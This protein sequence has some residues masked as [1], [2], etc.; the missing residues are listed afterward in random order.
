MDIIEK[1]RE[2]LTNIVDLAFSSGTEY[3]KS[4]STERVE[5]SIEEIKNNFQI[6]CND[7]FKKSQNLLIQEIS[8]YQDLQRN[9]VEN[10]KNY[11]KEKNRE[12]AKKGETQIKIIEQRI[13]SLMHVGDGI[14]WHILKGNLHVMRRYHIQDKSTKYL[15]S[16][17]LK[18]AIKSADTIN[19]NPLSFAL[20]CDI[21]NS[22]QIGDLLISEKGT[23][24]VEELKEGKVNEML[25]VV[26]DEIEKNNSEEENDTIESLGFDK[27]TKKQIER[28]IRQRKRI[29]QTKEVIENDKGIDNISGQKI[30][31]KESIVKD[32]KYYQ[33]LVESYKNLQNN[34]WSY[35]TVEECLHI[36]MYRDESILMAPFTIDHII[37]SKTKN[38]ITVD[39]LS[40]T[41]NLSEPIFF[42]PFPP[43]FIF[44]ILTG[45][46]K[47]IIGLDFDEFIKILNTNG[48]K[49]EWMSRKETMKIRQ[50]IKIKDL[51][52][53][54]DQAIKLSIN[55]EYEIFLCGG[56]I[57]KILYDSFYPSNIILNIN[58]LNANDKKFINE[59]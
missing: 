6:A 58:S 54:N 2:T 48:V 29:K 24:R 1:F 57:S 56:F 18:H 40:I 33:E 13:S 15:D 4:N 5:K 45:K 46:V 44:D 21:T 14:A 8:K 25:N 51:V 20:L 34:S 50:K 36:G 52:I 28:M 39:W 31:L 17:N 37:S 9:E 3:I 49:A 27:N 7:G 26:I 30:I 22:I 43:D 55:P 23:I 19:E 41:K 59:N 11:R 16:S 53:I 47:V 42:K 10:L 12:K 32:E 35:L 38:F